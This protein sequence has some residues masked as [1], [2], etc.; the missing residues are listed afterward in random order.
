MIR[1]VFAKERG[2][3]LTGPGGAG[4]YLFGTDR[5]ALYTMSDERAEVGSISERQIPESGRR[6]VIHENE[7]SVSIDTSPIRSWPWQKSKATACLCFAARTLQQCIKIPCFSRQGCVH[8]HCGH[9]SAGVCVNLSIRKRHHNRSTIDKS[10]NRENEMKKL[11]FVLMLLTPYIAAAQSPIPAG[12]KVEKLDSTFL[13]PEGPVWIDSLG[14][15]FSDIQQNTIF[16]WSPA[17]STTTVYLHP[18]DSSNGLT[19]DLQGRLILTQMELRRVSRRDPDG[20]I[21]PL[22]STF[23]GKKYNSPN[24][25]VVKS[26][27]SVFF[28]DPDF[29]IPTGQSREL[30]FKG[31][32]RISPTGS[33]KLLDSTFDKPNGICFSP[34]ESKLYVNESPKD[35]I[36]VWDV[37]NDSTITNKRGFFHIPQSGYADGMKADSVGNIYCTGPTGVWIVSPS[38]AYVDKIAVPQNPSNCSWGDAERK[39]L[40][41]T[42]GNSLYRIRLAIPGAQRPSPPP[43]T[44]TETH[45]FLPPEKFELYANYPNPF[46]P[47]TVISYDLPA[48]QAGLPV[49][50]RV[51]LKV[52]DLLGNEVATLEDGLKMSGSYSRTFDGSG[53]ASGIYFARLSAGSSS[54]T[55]KLILVK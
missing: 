31:I 51:C 29:N 35:S 16:R 4:M 55:Q 30:P 26:D 27:G 39:T 10:N 17:E 34:D 6:E 15:I 12:A 7:P 38:G 40:Y 21:A 18:S 24:D 33:V 53:L 46:N 52:Y 37:V 25:V 14:I 47:K 28:T 23:R 50:S 45:G 1:R 19:V 11:F 44:G 22:T 5:F 43:P 13:Q 49:M 9:T 36:Y 20:T 54:Q 3:Q 48:G 8:Y 2:L 41:I 42:A 32:Y